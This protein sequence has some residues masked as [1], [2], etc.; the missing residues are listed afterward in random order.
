MDTVDGRV[1]FIT[2]AGSGIGRATALSLARRG[3]AV[4]V[5][6][7]DDARASSVR[8]EIGER[9]IA[10]RVDVSDLASIEGARQ[11]C[12]DAFGRV[13][14]VMS[15]VGILAKGLVLDI[16]LEAWE[17]ILD[18]NVLGMVRVIRTFLPDLIA[19]GSG[20]VI[21]TGSASGLFPSSYDRLPYSA[22]KGAVIQMT[23]ALALWLEPQ[24]IQVSCLCPAGVMTN[25]VEQI[26][27]YGPP[28]PVQ[29]PR[30]PIATAEE[31]GERV[32]E[33]IL[34]NRFLIVSHD[35]VYDF[36][37]EHGADVDAFLKQQLEIGLTT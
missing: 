35:D 7:V 19:Q 27:E 11:A 12:L 36:N 14:I 31:V 21:T 26:K 3:A 22:S 30:I 33:G 24:G 8:D 4:M 10:A 17:R 9:A 25:I 29:A 2:G 32:V 6:D 15:N 23:E 28:T 16:P 20:H 37:R 34:A 18:V 13:D 1:A 5:S